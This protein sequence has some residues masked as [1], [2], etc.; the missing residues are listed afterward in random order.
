MDEAA[1]MIMIYT[2]FPSESD[3]RNLGT[4]LVELGL[5]ACVNI[6]P[7]MISVYRWQES[8]ETANET[9]MI[10]KTRKA[11][12]SQSL[13]AIAARHP[14]TV[15][16]LIVLEPQHVTAKYLEWLCDQTSASQ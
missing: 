9:A 3:A 10:V 12:Q 4:Q 16:A 8:L 7:G 11:L 5:A 15:P 13:D 1:A 2:T 14:Y 6:F